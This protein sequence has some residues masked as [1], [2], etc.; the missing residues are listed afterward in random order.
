VAALLAAGLLLAPGP[1]HA[2]TLFTV[3]SVDDVGDGT[4][5]ASE[6]TLREAITASNNTP[7]GNVIEFEIPESEDPGVKTISP[8]SPLPAITGTVTIDGCTQ[9][10]ARKNTA[11]VGTDANLLIELSGASTVGSGLVIEAS[12]VT[13]RGLVINGF[14]DGIRIASGATEVTVEGNFFGTD[15]TG[16]LDR[17]NSSN[18]VSIAEEAANNTVGGAS[19]AARN[20]ISGNDQEGVFISGGAS[21]N[22]VLGNLIGTEKDGTT[23]QGN[24]QEGVE[25]A[26][27]ASN[28][29]GDGTPGAANTIAFNG[30]H[31]VTVSAAGSEVDN[32]NGNRILS[33]SIHS[34][35]K[36][37]IALSSGLSTNDARPGPGPQPPPELPGSD[38]RLH[39]ERHD[40]R[41]GDPQKHPQKNLQ[42]PVLLKP[43]GGPVRQR[44]GQDL[45]WRDNREDQPQGQPLLQRDRECAPDRGA[46]GRGALDNRHGH[47]QHDRGHLRV[48]R[49]RDSCSAAPLACPLFA[50]N[51]ERVC[52]EH[53]GYAPDPSG[54]R[55]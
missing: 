6:C 48:L 51:H 11:Q 30:D 5:N 13:V 35:A 54:E 53:N 16:T 32:A 12:N 4:C 38:L 42:D 55:S 10:G 22:E 43:P 24:L 28:T 8:S 44:R 3:N 29:V 21:G 7:G 31:G 17:G 25:I 15:A 41:R 50:R 37:G 14:S 34:N 52:L 1:A 23:T 2:S 39:L 45:P 26:G 9:T 36:V 46:L 49:S 27:A 20:L 19:L 33:N 47:P 18:G 40:H